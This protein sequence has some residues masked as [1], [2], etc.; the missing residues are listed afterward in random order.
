[1]L[2]YL[3]TL[4][5]VNLWLIFL[6]ENLLVTLLALITGT[7][8]LK[9][10]DKP[11]NKPTVNE[12]LICGLTNIINTII[13]FTGFR[14]WQLG[15]ISLELNPGWDILTDFALLFLLMDLA[16]YVFHFLIHR[17]NFI[18]RHIHKFHHQ[19]EN[20]I[21][22]DL[23]VL[24]P[25]ETVSFGTLWLITISLLHFNFYAIAAYLVANVIF[26]TIGHLGFEPLPEKFT[27]NKL[28]R[29]IGTSTFHHRHHLDVKHNFGFYTS[30]WDRIF[31]TYKS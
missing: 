2:E 25:L 18:Y 9:L 4:S 31:N 16:M 14:L 21:P 8:I 23:F 13:T 20:P 15:Y 24:H 28:I 5:T 11:V 29:Y 3:S 7:A 1:M 30:I 27:N 12:W 26:G 6:A 17:Y 19:Y 10:S 22:I